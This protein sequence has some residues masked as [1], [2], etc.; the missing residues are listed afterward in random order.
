MDPLLG[1]AACNCTLMG[2]SA[3]A[4]ATVAA[5]NNPSCRLNG[6]PLVV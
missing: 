1:V 4:K 5:A 3:N 2:T 6:S